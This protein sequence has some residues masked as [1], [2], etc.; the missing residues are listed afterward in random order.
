MSKK[1]KLRES[2]YILEESSDIYKVIFT[3]TRRVK[4]FEVDGLVKRIIN[5]LKVGQDV[6]L[7][8]DKLSSDYESGKVMTCLKSLGYEGIIREDDYETGE[9]YSKQMLFIGELTNSHKETISL[10]KRLEDSTISVFGI[11]GIGTWIVNGLYQLG[12][13]EIRIADPDVVQKS[14]LNDNCFLMRE[15]LED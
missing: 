1:I 9:R 6:D 14:N 13:G 2:I 5:E 10:Q 11:G 8:V 4:T 7:L 12:I 3:G 15:I